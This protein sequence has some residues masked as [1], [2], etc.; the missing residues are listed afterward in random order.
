MFK[1]T[2]SSVL[3]P[4][5]GTEN[6]P[7]SHSSLS[8]DWQHG[9]G[10]PATLPPLVKHISSSTVVPVSTCYCLF[11]NIFSAFF[12]VLPE[13]LSEWTTDK[14]NHIIF[15]CFG[16]VS[17][18]SWVSKNGTMKSLDQGHLHPKLEV[19]SLKCPGR[20]SN[21]G[22]HGER[23]ALQKR[24]IRIASSYLEHLLMSLRQ[25]KRKQ[26]RNLIYLKFRRALCRV[27]DFPWSLD[28]QL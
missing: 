16:S 25:K 5:Q 3:N 22:L 20:K 28:S 17:V 19:L 7:G 21:P 15:Q 27:G 6:R 4:S 8:R 10:T 18:F 9:K 23:R 14:V 12:Q 1:Y 2:F 26:L 24:A 13:Y 11:T